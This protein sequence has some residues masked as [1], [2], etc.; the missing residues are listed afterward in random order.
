M[1]NLIFII[2]FNINAL[3]AFSQTRNLLDYLPVNCVKDGTVDYTYYI[4]KSLNENQTVLFPNFPLLVNDQGLRLRSGQDIIFQDR[5]KLILKS[6]KKGRYSLI[7]IVGVNNITLR[8]VRIEGDR[9]SHIGSAGEWGMGIEIKD[10]KNVT[11]LSPEISKFWGDGIYITGRNTNNVL[12]NG[13]IIK[14]N[15]RNGVSI[16][17]GSNIRLKG[18]LIQDT[19]NGV[20]P[21]SAIDIEPNSF[22]K[23]YLGK[24][25][26]EDIT[27]RN[28][29]R[30]VSIVLSNYLSEN[31]SLIDITVSG[32]RS[33]GDEVGIKVNPFSSKKI[34]SKKVAQ[35]KG[36]V[37]FEN[38]EMKN[39]N[40]DPVMVI[41]K[42]EDYT[43]AP[44]FVFR[45]ISIDSKINLSNKFKGFNTR[46]FSLSK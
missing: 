18:I 20:H 30:G 39:V 29:L 17:S 15:R 43:L 45:N 38:I 31:P 6:S 36:Q 3:I 9:Y 19:K 42:N 11:I 37:L 5:S 4:Q 33:S 41:G 27:S 25:T 21:M 40:R 12:V 10:S 7:H 24:I 2:V 22:E 16:I 13:G 35:L 28:N 1:K 44:N 46:K 32:F 26:L 8:N 14:N 23:D 34:R